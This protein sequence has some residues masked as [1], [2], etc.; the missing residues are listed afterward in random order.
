MFIEALIEV[1]GEILTTMAIT[2]DKDKGD[3]GCLIGAI[4]IV[5]ILVGIGTYIYLN[6]SE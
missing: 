6:P 1:V 2:G 5:V 4:V 3:K